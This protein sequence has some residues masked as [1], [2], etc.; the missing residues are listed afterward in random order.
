VWVYWIFK[1]VAV[2]RQGDVVEKEREKNFGIHKKRRSASPFTCFIL[3][4]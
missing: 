2:V 3:V 4:P 1:M